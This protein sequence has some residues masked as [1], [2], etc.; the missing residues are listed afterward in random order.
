MT[1][2]ADITTESV[3]KEMLQEN[4]GAHF[5]DSGS[6][7]GRHHERNQGR[8]FDSEEHTTLSV[9]WGE[10]EISHNVYHWLRDKISYSPEWDDR[11]N[12]YAEERDPEDELNWHQLM[13][14]YPDYLESKGHNI[15]RDYTMTVNTYNGEDLLSQTIQYTQISVD[16]ETVILLQ[17]HGG[18]DVRGGY[19]KPRAFKG[20]D[21]DEFPLS[22]NADA[23]IWCSNRDCGANWSTDDSYNWYYDGCSPSEINLRELSIIDIEEEPWQGEDMKLYHRDGAPLCPSCG[24]RLLA[25]F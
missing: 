17:I 18:C 5:L 11:F 20:D 9:K 15:N 3:L 13:V 1:A 7:Y 2:T 24:E 19:T 23:Y 16:G 10:V 6:A 25:G 22:R 21:F 8:D 4:T 12:Q 14:E